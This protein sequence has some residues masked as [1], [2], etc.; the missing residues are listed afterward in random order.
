[1]LNE[2]SKLRFLD[3]SPLTNCI[4]KT[5]QGLDNTLGLILLHQPNHPSPRNSESSVFAGNLWI[6]RGS[7]KATPGYPARFSRCSY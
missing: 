2:Y 6:F 5:I 4:S 1:M 3:S 7:S